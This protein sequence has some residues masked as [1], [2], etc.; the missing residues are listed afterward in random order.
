LQESNKELKIG[1]FVIPKIPG[2]MFQNEPCYVVTKINNKQITIEQNI[3][4]YKHILIIN[5][6]KLEV[7]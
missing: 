1:S 5:K 4:C 2:V 7:L 6:N 3:G